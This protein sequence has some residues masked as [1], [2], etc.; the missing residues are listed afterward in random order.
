MLICRTPFRL[1][2]FGGGTDFPSWYND[3]NGMVISTTINKYCYVV[4]RI[5]PPFF[6]YKYR[7]RYFKNEMI[8][9]VKN[10]K[11]KSIKAVLQKYNKNKYGLEIIHSA[12]LPAMSG[13]GASSAFTVSLIN[14]MHSINEEK[15]SKRMLGFKS[16]EIEQKILKENVGSQDQFACAF[17]GFNAINFAKENIEVE[18]MLINEKIKKL[19]MSNITL[20]FTGYPR[21]ANIIEKSKLKIMNEKNYIYNEIYNTA[22]E[23][24]KLFYSKS[25]SNIL[26]Q[27]GE[28]MRENWKLKTSL[29]SLVTNKDID[30]VYQYGMK[31]GAIAGKLTGA[32]G[33]GFMLFLSENKKEKKKLESKLQRFK[34]VDVEYD[35]TGSQIIY[36]DRSDRYKFNLKK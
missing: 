16:I 22:K 11:H 36:H 28:L 14:L 34:I 17:G 35:E 6:E 15:I 13:L 3:N 29:S 19:L 18:P 21:K 4:L 27:I 26:R 1:S 32:G 12:D 5:L 33:G 31:N 25:E 23:A 9:D 20:F 7:L 24:Q 10:V 30:E 2:L 8:T